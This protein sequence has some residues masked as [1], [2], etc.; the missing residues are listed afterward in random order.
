MLP[1]SRVQSLLAPLRLRHGRRLAPPTV[2]MAAA[3]SA[4]TP[5][6]TPRLPRRVGPTAGG[7]G[8][9]GAEAGGGRWWGRR[10]RDLLRAVQRHLRPPRG[11]PRWEAKDARLRGAPLP[12]RHARGQ[13]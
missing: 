2:A 3:A 13:H 7:G 5:S 10:R 12:A 1:L 9:G 6:P 11:D 8:G 4:I